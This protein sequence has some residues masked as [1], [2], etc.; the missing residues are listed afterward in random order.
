M[1]RR[2]LHVAL[3]AVFAAAFAAALVNGCSAGQSRNTGTGGASGTGAAGSGGAPQGSSSSMGGQGGQG[4]IIFVTDAGVDGD[5]NDE[6]IT[7]PC[8]TECGPTELCDLAHLGLDDNCNGE[9]DEICTCNPGQVHWCFAGDPSYHNAPGCYDGVESCNELGFWGPCIGGVQAIPPDNCFLNNTTA[10]HAITTPPGATVQLETGTGQFSIN[11]VPGSETF[12]VTCPTTGTTQCPAVVAPDSFTPI[13]SGEYTVTYTKSV[14]GSASPLSCTFPLF[15]GAPGLRVELT[16]E[17]TLADTGVD[18]DLHVHQPA[19]G[20]LGTT[21]TKPADCCSA[22]CTGGVCGPGGCRANA[23]PCS[24]NGQCCSGTCVAGACGPVASM[25]WG[26]SPGVAQD[27][28]WSTCRIAQL[29]NDLPPFLSDAG[30]PPGLSHWFP[31]TNLAPQPADWDNMANP[32]DNTCYGDARGAGALWQMLGIGCHNPRSDIDVITCE[33]AI[34][35]INN[36]EWCGPENINIDYPTVGQWYRTGV[37]YYNNHGLTY[38]VH[39]DVKIYCNGSLA[40]DLGPQG[41]YMPPSAVTFEPGDGAGS[42]VG[43]RFWVVADVAFTTDGCGNTT[44]V[45]QPIYSDPTNLTPFFIL[46]TAA[47]TSFQPAWP[48]PP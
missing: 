18:L 21:C 6:L 32:M 36:P 15:V 31:D 30:T 19:C 11:A 48:P 23:Q 34:T 37:H 27:C 26:V 41:Y 5:A 10:C 2:P 42:G 25:P 45:V 43:N 1:H 38:D 20:T 14:A 13:Q 7:N 33:F 44:C 4:G 16:W 22:L 9:V 3:A 47:T 29:Q 17:H 46:D 24:T 28:T 39:P 8:G 40:A 12:T 35:D